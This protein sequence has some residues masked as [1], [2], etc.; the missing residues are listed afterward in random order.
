[1]KAYKKMGFI[2]M[3]SMF[4]NT[5]AWLV[6]PSLN[7][8]VEK[9]GNQNDCPSIRHNSLPKQTGSHFFLFIKS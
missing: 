5:P 7:S 2:F 8:P 6:T 1:M 4:R 3:V 9:L